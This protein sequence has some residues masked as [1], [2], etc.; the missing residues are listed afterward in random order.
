MLKKVKRACIIGHF[1]FGENLLNGQTIKTQIVTDELKKVIGQDNIIMTDTHGGIKQ[2]MFLPFRILIS[3]LYSKNIIIMPAQNGLRIISPILFLENIFL[4]RKIHYMVVGGW[5]PE[6]IEKKNILQYI[7]KKFH[8]IY[9]ETEI[10]KN[11]LEI[12]GFRN[13]SVIPNC[14]RLRIMDADEVKSDFELPYRLCTFSRVMKEKG[15]EEAVNAVKITNDR[16]GKVLFELDIYG[17]V[18][19]E[20]IDWFENLRSTFPKYIKYGGE[21]PFDK[22]TTVLKDYFALLFPTYYSGEGFAGTIIDSMASG[23][24][25]IASDWRYN[26]EIIRN[27]ENGILVEPNNSE[28]L[29]DILCSISKDSKNWIRMRRNCITESY[30]YVPSEALKELINNL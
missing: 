21:I 13:V 5:L 12:Y 2:I 20:Q 18:D 28:K 8:K 19:T 14:K 24:P 7:L 16:N 6:F 29:A 10:M 1:G 17:Q 30:K 26:S 11:K 25:V 15:I 23:V 4:K 22:S 3:L 9:V 27:N